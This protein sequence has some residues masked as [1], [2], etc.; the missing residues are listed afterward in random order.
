MD[1]IDF[2]WISSIVGDDDDDDDD[3]DD[4]DGDGDDDDDESGDKD[5]RRTS[6]TLDA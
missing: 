1:F 3:D 2:Q 4:G 5:V 6:H